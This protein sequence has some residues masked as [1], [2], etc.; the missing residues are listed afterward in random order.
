MQDDLPE[1]KQPA[2]KN[3]RSGTKRL[4]TLEKT[5]QEA[6]VILKVCFLLIISWFNKMK[7]S[8]LILFIKTNIFKQTFFALTKIKTG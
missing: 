5:A 2:A 3:K 7:I 4:S 6:D 8:L 1:E